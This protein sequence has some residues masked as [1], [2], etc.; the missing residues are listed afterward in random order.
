M[1]TTFPK[2]T[3]R[4]RS[5]G[6]GEMS[7]WIRKLPEVASSTFIASAP[8]VMTAGYV[9][10][11]ADP[12]TKVYGFALRA[13]R[14]GA[15]DGLYD[16]E[17]VVAFPGLEFY[18]N[19]LNTAGTTTN[20]LDVSTDLAVTTPW[21]LQTNDVAPGSTEMWHVADAT[22]VAG[23]ARMVSLETDYILPNVVNNTY[24]IEADINAR[25]TFA[26]AALANMYIG[27]SG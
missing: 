21:D 26:V 11:G 25:V 22:A 18:A 23:S 27:P 9:T 16:S 6:D 8:I 2:K 1:A 12:C 24:A 3:L 15:S 13:G 20:V 4:V 14:N 5:P 17:V 7:Y 10:E 19:F